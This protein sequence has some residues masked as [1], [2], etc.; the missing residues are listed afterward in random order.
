MAIGESDSGIDWL[1][2]ILLVILVASVV[3][4]QALGSLNTMADDSANF[5]L[6]QRSLIALIGT[7][8]LIMFV[9]RI[10]KGK[11]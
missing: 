1:I 3:L 6:A 10:Y 7:V 9:Y 8:V 11:Q 2:G 4:P 5:S